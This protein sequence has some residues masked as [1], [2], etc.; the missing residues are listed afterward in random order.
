MVHVTV[1]LLQHNTLNFP[2]AVASNSPELN[3]INY[4]IEGVTQQRH[5]ELQLV[6]NIEEIKQQCDW[7]QQ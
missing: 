3:S 4:K 1:Q 5:Y 6:D 2:S 7:L